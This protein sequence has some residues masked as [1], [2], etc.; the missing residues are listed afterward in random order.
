MTQQFFL[1]VPAKDIKRYGRQEDREYFSKP[2]YVE[3]LYTD[4]AT[5]FIYVRDPKRGTQFPLTKKD[6]KTA[7]QLTNKQ[8][9]QIGLP[10]SATYQRKMAKEGVV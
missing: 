2:I 1:V 4:R 3:L 10:V 5:K 9:A 6:L 8:K 7:N